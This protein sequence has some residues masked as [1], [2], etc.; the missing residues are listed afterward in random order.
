MDGDS[1]TIPKFTP[2]VLIRGAVNSPVG[3]AYTEGAKL[4][5]YV[6][7][8]GG[9]TSLGDRHR[10]YVMQPNGKVETGRRRMLF[11]RS[12]PIPHPGSTVFVPNKDPNDQRNWGQIA[13]VATSILGSLVAIAAIAR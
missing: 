12:E 3:V 5:Y 9:P 1:I 4:G 13:T 2:V 10:A 8:G 6:R 7:S 11:W